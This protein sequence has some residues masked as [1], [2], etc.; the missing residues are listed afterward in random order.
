MDQLF[1]T[2]E[3]QSIL[4]N[5]TGFNN[6]LNAM[7]GNQGDSIRQIL[8]NENVL[9]DLLQL[10]PETIRGQ[11]EAMLKSIFHTPQKAK[12][13]YDECRFMEARKL[14][15]K[16]ISLYSLKPK[17]GDVFLDQASEF[18]VKRST[19]LLYCLLGEV[20]WELGNKETAEKKFQTALSLAR[21]VDDIDTIAK[22]LY[23]LGTYYWQLDDFET[24]LTY[25]NRALK[26][27]SGHDDQWH[28]Q[29]KVLTNLCGIHADIGQYSQALDYGHKAVSLCEKDLAKTSLPISC[30]NL[31]SLY[32]KDEAYDLAINILEKGLQ[33]AKKNNA[34]QQEVIILNNMAVCFLRHSPEGRHTE[35]VEF[36]LARALSIVKN[37]D[38][39]SLKALTFFNLGFL[40]RISGKNQRAKKYFTD[41]IDIYQEIGS[42]S[43]QAQALNMLGVHLSASLNDTVEALKAYKKSIDIIETI[44]GGLAK[45]A[46]RISYADT[47]I[48]PYENAIDCLLALHLPEEAF[49]YAERAK[50]R[51]LMEFLSDKLID[52]TDTPNADDSFSHTSKLLRQIEELQ[53]NLAAVRRK[54]EDCSFTRN[55]R[56]DF[57]DMEKQE[58]E[59]LDAIEKKTGHSQRPTRNW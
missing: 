55:N 26:L 20:E 56:S 13:L 2:S 58:Q 48:E 44:R 5:D 36:L 15:N 42:R 28:T 1:S 50:S 40:S 23:G 21:E 49:V 43:L 7:P 35:T 47:V 37:T 27:L 6:L 32:I 38:A 41:A 30:N 54:K 16:T 45:E 24:S 9:A 17:T 29:H 18:A 11:A 8:L 12:Q 10:L 19:A 22:S 25:N 52:H 53:L 34:L 4:K 39:N 59:L 46:F 14:L 3:L 33:A 51:T 31:A 57:C